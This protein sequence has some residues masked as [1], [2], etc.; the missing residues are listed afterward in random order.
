[1]VALLQHY[2][3]HLWSSKN[4]WLGEISDSHGNKYEDKSLL[5]PFSGWWLIITWWRQ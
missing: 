2:A 4:L 3:E 5:P 1:L